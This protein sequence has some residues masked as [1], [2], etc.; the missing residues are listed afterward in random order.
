MNNNARQ[1][2]RDNRLRG[3]FRGMVDKIVEKVTG[4]KGM[5]TTIE[6]GIGQGKEPLQGV[7]EETEVLAMIGPDQ[8]PELVQ[9]R[10]G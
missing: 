1:N 10:I 5:L 3:N 4:M 2:Y 8:G 9:I 7:I 6:I